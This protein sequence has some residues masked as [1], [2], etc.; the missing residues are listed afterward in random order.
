MRSDLDDCW[1]LSQ[2][3]LRWSTDMKVLNVATSKY[4]VLKDLLSWRHRSIGWAILC[5]KR[6][7]CEI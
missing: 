2:C 6:L 4:D 1:I 5:T 7:H 3:R